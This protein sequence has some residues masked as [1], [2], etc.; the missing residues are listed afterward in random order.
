MKQFSFLLICAAFLGFSKQAG[1]AITV[2]QGTGGTNICSSLA[3]G[4]SSPAF[5]TLGNITVTEGVVTDISLGAHTLTLNAP[6]GWKFNTVA[7]TFTFTAARNITSVTLGSITAASLTLNVTTSGIFLSDAFKIIGLQVQAT[8]T[9]S[10]GGNITASAAAGMNGI[11]VNVTNFASL[12]LAATPGA[13]TVTGGGTFCDNATINASLAGP[14]TIFYEG[15]TSGSTSTATPSVS[16]SVT[17]QGTHTYYFR[18][19]SV[20]GACWGTEGSAAVTINQTPGPVAINPVTT[21]TFCMGDSALFIASATAPTV[22]L[23]QQDFNTGLGAWTI[24]NNAG[25]PASEWQIRTSPGYLSAIA[26]DGSPYLEATPDVTGTATIPTNT[27]ITSPSFA[28]TGFISA[29]ITFNQFYRFFAFDTSASVEYSTDGGTTWTVIVNQGVGGTGAD[30][31]ATTWVSTT[32]NTTLALPVAALDMPSVMLRWNY[33]SEWGWYWAIDNIA[34]NGVPTLSYTWAGVAGATGLSCTSCDT[35][36]ITPA[37]T[38]TNTY[39]VTTTQAGCTSS[40]SIDLT[41]VP[42]PNVFTVMGG[43]SYCAG[44]TGVNV[45]L[46]GSDAGVN[47]QLYNGTTTVGGTVPGTG[48]VLDFGAQTA[49]GTYTVQATDPLASCSS[50]M[51]DSAVITITPLPTVMPVIGD[52]TVC[53]GAFKT[54]IDST[55][56]GVW[57]TADATIADV[58]AGGIVSGIAIGATT[59]SYTVTALGCSDFAILPLSVGNAMAPVSITPMVATMCHGNP[60]NLVAVTSGVTYQWEL[61][62]TVIPG[63]TDAT[64]M[65]TAPGTYT[66]VMDNGTCTMNAPN[67]VISPSPTPVI[68]LNTSGGYLY[69]GSFITYQW[70]KNGTVIAGATSS[71]YPPISSGVYKVI[72][73]DANGCI[74]TSAA[75]NYLPTGITGVSVTDQ[76]AF[77]P[78]P[79]ATVLNIDAPYKVNVTIIAPDGRIVLEQKDAA[80]INVAHLA[81]GIYMIMVYD[82]H[83]TLVKTGKF[84]KVD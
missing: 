43:G 51:L 74:D 23:L 48:S 16:Q 28:T 62:D 64:Y 21:T 19:R 79:A 72:V 12:S 41:V 54:L 33:N 58:S 84:A 57:T 9:A 25:I 24:T 17:L 5:T 35:T 13:V 50:N 49:A 82:E 78:N 6:A 47:Y 44:G 77:F 75:Y 70:L 63:A 7:P 4:G 73:K 67:V 20:A 14:G 68:A 36:Q 60:V 15:V 37:M 2:T 40:G 34:V 61:A 31:G 46:A 39:S 30:A 26:G 10:A 11:V 65:A 3:V 71:I 83:N 1:A 38:G 69:T 76:I 22:E 81:D 42:M 8:S 27:V 18:A 56:G 32:P 53:L 55:P 29:N 66:L 80:A 59:I 45:L 52:P